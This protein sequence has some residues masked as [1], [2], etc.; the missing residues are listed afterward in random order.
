[1]HSFKLSFMQ[2]ILPLNIALLLCLIIGTRVSAQVIN[3]GF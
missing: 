1:M 3:E 2:K